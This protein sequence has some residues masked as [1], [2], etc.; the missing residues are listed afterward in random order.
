MM[1]RKF[2]SDL[3]KLK[4]NYI[5]RREGQQL[6]FKEQFN[7]GGL[8]EYFRD[9][10]AFA[11]NRGG[12]LIFGIKDIPHLPVGLILLCQIKKCLHL[13]MSFCLTLWR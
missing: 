1:N 6:E 3:L 7:F 5:F 2:L 13:R 9:F 8:A 4:G 12:Y 10:A 11:N